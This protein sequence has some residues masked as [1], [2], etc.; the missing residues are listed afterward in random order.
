MVEDRYLKSV[1]TVIACSL[2]V[3]AWAH[4]DGPAGIARAS[5]ERAEVVP[6]TGAAGPY[7]SQ[8]ADHPVRWRV[9]HAT[10][11]TG[12]SNTYCSTAISVTNLTGSTIEAEVEWVNAVGNAI[13][14]EE[15]F[16]VA[17][18]NKTFAADTDVNPGPWFIQNSADL[19]DFGGYALVRAEDPRV[20][21]GAVEFCREGL[22]EAALVSLVTIPAYPVGETV[23]YFRAATPVPG[24]A[25]TAAR[26]TSGGR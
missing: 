17:G 22:D 19:D 3:V 24:P 11:E 21:V 13:G 10:E 2:S 12:H 8:D 25:L 14:V 4:L 23:Q 16:L 1:L 26:P 20:M 5:G 15:E 18:E 9:A 6:V 7:Q